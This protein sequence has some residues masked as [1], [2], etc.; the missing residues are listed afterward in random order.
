MDNKDNNVLYDPETFGKTKKS[1]SQLVYELNNPT[2]KHEDEK[3]E[4]KTEEIKKKSP[5][6]N[7]SVIIIIILV[8]VILLVSYIVYDKVIKDILNNNSSSLS[9]EQAIVVKELD[10]IVE[11][12]LFILDDKLKYDDITNQ[13]LLWLVSS[14]LK[15]DNQLLEF[16]G[17][18]AKEY[19]NTTSFSRLNIIN[20]SIYCYTSIIEK[21]NHIMWEYNKNKDI[22]SY[23]EVEH[24]NIVIEKVLRKVVDFKVM[25]DDKYIISFKNVFKNK[26]NNFYGSYIDALNNVNELIV[27]IK[28]E[29]INNYFNINY[30]AIKDKLST[31][32]Y[33]F[34]KTDNGYKLIDYIVE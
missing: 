10:N 9:E 3:P 15:K 14:N 8:I 32:T 31:Y 26:D 23:V 21:N 6:R 11:S 22:Y 27:D 1:S 12:E 24:N 19:F 34:E 5:K 30:D 20:T 25:M 33:T 4:I 18:T 13:D 2:I 28:E 16:S 17:T 7:Y 29:D